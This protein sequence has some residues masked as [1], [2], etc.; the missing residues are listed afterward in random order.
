MSRFDQGEVCCW[1][2]HKK[3]PC[4]VTGAFFLRAEN[5]KLNQP[6]EPDPQDP[7][8]HPPPPPTGLVEVMEKPERYPAS[9]KSTLIAPQVS[10]RPWSTRKVNLSSSKILSFSFDSSRAKPRDG[11]DQPPCINAI[12]TAESILFCDRYSF[13]FATAVLVTSNM[14]SSIVK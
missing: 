13:R 6:Q 2:G 3:S 5:G 14:T 7:E 1:R 9:M 10:S 11:P 12:R 4:R 8:L